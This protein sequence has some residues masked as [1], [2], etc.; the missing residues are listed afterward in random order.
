MRCSINREIH[1][2]A[3]RL[4]KRDLLLGNAVLLEELLDFDLL[5]L[6]E[7]VTKAIKSIEVIVKVLIPVNKLVLV[8]HALMEHL[9]LRRLATGMLVNL[10][11]GGPGL[12]VI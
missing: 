10:H 5:L 2:L 3:I 7:R 8:S 1:P 4:E 11:V 12:V 6:L 9:L